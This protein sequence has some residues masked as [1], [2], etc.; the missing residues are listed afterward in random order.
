MNHLKEKVKNNTITEIE[1]IRLELLQ[2]EY[3]KLKYM[4]KEQT[5]PTD[6]N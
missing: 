2:E 6:K 1:S 5:K 3:E 4:E